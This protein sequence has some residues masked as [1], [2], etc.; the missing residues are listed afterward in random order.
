MAKIS[1]NGIPKVFMAHIFKSEEYRNTLVKTKNRIEISYF[2]TDGGYIYISGNK[3]KIE[4]GGVIVNLFREDVTVDA[5]LPHCHH[6]VS[7]YVSFSDGEEDG[8]A[9]VD[10]PEYLLPKSGE[11]IY[12][13][14]DEI[15][16][17]HT[18]YP[19]DTLRASGLAL[20][21]MSQISLESKR[22]DGKR[23][24]GE[25]RYVRRAKQYIYNHINE[26]IESR[27]VAK[28]LGITPEYLCS[29]FKLCEGKTLMSYI[30]G[31]KLEGIKG[32]VEDGKQ[33]LAEAALLYGY[34]DPNYASRLFRRFYGMS[35]TD[36]IAGNNLRK[37]K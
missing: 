2:T 18:I 32:L 31:I 19:D 6:T 3:H 36:C 15:I 30:N 28:H 34:S 14:I 8:G 27:E 12:S 17:V 37:Y 5:P 25:Y 23:V 26:P 35:L 20:E 4:E 21:L 1:L 22:R 24:T 33:T 13:L 11:K 16:R 7:F 10:L 29:V 9:A